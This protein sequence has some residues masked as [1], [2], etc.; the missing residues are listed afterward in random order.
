MGLEDKIPAGFLLGKVED[1]AGWSRSSS[2]W[3]ATFGLA[4]CAIE[5]MAAGTSR[6]DISR[7]VMVVFR[8]SPRQAT[9][10]IIAERLSPQMAP[11]LC[12]MFELVAI[13][14]WDIAIG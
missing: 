4:C 8:T 14:N 12:T 2:M 3:P 9:L 7:F 1:I 5:M 13:T 11:V 10:L 6:Y